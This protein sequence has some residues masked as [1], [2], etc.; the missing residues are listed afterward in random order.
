MT[1]QIEDG[2]PTTLYLSSAYLSAHNKK[3][4]ALGHDEIF[5]SVSDFLEQSSEDPLPNARD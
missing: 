5:D 1:W 3:R 4:N 2:R